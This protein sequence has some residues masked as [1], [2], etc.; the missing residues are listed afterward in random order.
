MLKPYLNRKESIVMTTIEIIDELG[1]Q[2]LSTR[3]IAKRQEIS[4][5]TL[6][7]H[8]KSKNEIILTVLDKF[9]QFDDEIIRS[10]ALKQLDPRESI[11]YFLTSYLEYYENYSA[12]TCIL[13]M[14][15]ILRSNCEVEK[16]I[17]EIFDKRSNYLKKL[18]EDAKKAGEIRTYIDSENLVDLIMGFCKNVIL[19]WRINHCNFSLKERILPTLHVIL[20]KC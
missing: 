6:F 2:G 14:D 3:E 1:I 5:G 12:I 9:S 4:E 19:R 16:K 11:I 17:R 15:D 7:K 20:N 13:Y 18:I 8:F 10:I